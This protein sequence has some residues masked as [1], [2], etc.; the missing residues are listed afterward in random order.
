MT[1]LHHALIRA[2]KLPVD[3][4]VVEG[5]CAALLITDRVAAQAV[6]ERV[7]EHTSSVKAMLVAMYC[8]L[9]GDRTDKVRFAVSA[10]GDARFPE[11]VTQDMLLQMMCVSTR[12]VCC[13]CVFVCECAVACEPS[14]VTG[15]TLAAGGVGRT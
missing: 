8:A 14:D 12:C 4:D 9:P 7:S 10:L 3:A 1:K 6:L 15:C 13:V 11:R 5:T 2:Q